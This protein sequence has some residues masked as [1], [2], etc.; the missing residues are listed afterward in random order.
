MRQLGEHGLVD[1]TSFEATF[2][3]NFPLIHL[4][5]ARRVGTARAD[6][7]A[8]ETFAVAYRRRA[9]F[10]P[11]RGVARA[12]L[13]GIAT[14]LLR[15]HRR[16][17]RRLL[18][19]E[20]RVAAEADHASTP[21][22]LALA[23]TLAPRVAQALARLPPGQRDVLLLYAWGELSSEEIAVTLGLRAVDGAIA[24][25]QGTRAPSRSAK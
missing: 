20:A 2:A 18:A 15:A 11:S 8:A 21:D 23:R 19:L 1:R 22:E 10:D 25:V 13:L 16:E 9:S 24:A 5:L 17:E 4:Y 12:W 7:L 6:D 3:E 14:N